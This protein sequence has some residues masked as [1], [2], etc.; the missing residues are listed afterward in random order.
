MKGSTS[1]GVGQQRVAGKLVAFAEQFIDLVNI[2]LAVAGRMAPPE[3]RFETGV[4]HVL[5]PHPP[6]D[7]TPGL[8]RQVRKGGLKRLEPA[9]E[10]PAIDQAISG[11]RRCASGG[12]CRPGWRPQGHQA[13]IFGKDVEARRR[14]PGYDLAPEYDAFTR[15]EELEG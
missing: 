7:Q 2:P 3:R 1:G 4:R 9:D 12:A 10:A 14:P 6:A 13:A 11:S 5:L 8:A 15:I